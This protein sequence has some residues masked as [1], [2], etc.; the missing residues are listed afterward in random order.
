MQVI[1]RT[2]EFY[3]SA[4]VRISD[5]FLSP[6]NQTKRKKVSPQRYDPTSVGRLL[7]FLL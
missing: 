6:H 1:D 2:I 5:T 4:I 7:L 3:T